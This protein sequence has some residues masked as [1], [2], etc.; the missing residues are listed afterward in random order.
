MRQLFGVFFIFIFGIAYA[1]PTEIVIETFAENIG[2]V[3][4]TDLTGY[5]TFRVYVKFSSPDDFLSAIYGDSDFPTRIYG[6]N[7]FFH[8]AVGGLTNEGYNPLVFPVVP[9][10]EYDSFV[11]IGMDSPANSDDGEQTINSIGDPLANWVSAFEPGAGMPGADLVIDT[12][13]GGSWFPLYPDANAFAG[14]DSMVLIGQFTTNQEFYGELSVASFIEGDMSN[15]NLMTMQFGLPTY[16][17]TDLQACNYNV[18]A[19]L[20]DGSCFYPS[21][22]FLD[23][24]GDCI[25]DSDGDGICDEQ[26]GCTISVACNYDPQAILDD[27]SCEFFCPG[28][29]N[30]S[31]CNFDSTALQEDGTCLFED[32]LGECG[33]TCTQD[34]DNDLVCDDIDP[35]I[36]EYDVCGVCNGPG[37][38]ATCGCS[39]VPEGFCDCNGNQIDALGVC[40]GGCL[41]DADGDGICDDVDDCVGEFDECGVCN[42]AGA[43]YECGCSGIPEGD[44]DCNGSVIDQC[45]NCGGDGQ[46]CVGCMYEFACNFDSNATISDAALCEFGTCPG[47]TDSDAFNYNPTVIED[48]GSCLFLEDFCADESACNYHPDAAEPVGPS[49]Y[50]IEVEVVSENIGPLV[51]PSGTT[52]LTGYTCYR[53][54]ITMENEDDFLS[55]ISGD[56]IN[57]TSVTTTTDFFHALLGNAT[58]NGIN[59]LLFGA[60][61]DTE[62]DSWVTIGLDGIPNASWGEAAV[63]T[64]QS[65]INP[66]T[67]TFDPGG[68]LPGGNI[69]IDDAIGGAW[70]ALNGDANGYAGEDLK[71]LAGQFTTTGDLSLSL[72]TQIFVEGVGSEVYLVNGERPT[73]NWPNPW[74]G[75]SGNNCIYPELYADCDG[76]CL[77]DDDGDGIC[78]D[79]DDC[80]GEIDECGVCNGAN[81]CGCMDALAC[82]Y[83]MEAVFDDAS[84]TYPAADYLDCNGDCLNDEDGDGLCDEEEGCGDP[85]ACNY[86]PTAL[87]EDDDYCLVVDTVLVH[88]SGNLAGMTT[89]RYYVKC[90]NPADFVSAI[91]GD[92]DNPTVITTTTEFYQDELG[93]VT[94]NS[95]VSFLFGTFPDLEYDSFVTIGLS[96]APVSTIGEAAV[97]TVQSGINPWTTTFDPGFGAAGG[98]IVINDAVGG[99]W[100]ALNGD[101]N[102]IAANHPNNEV[103]I[104]QLTTDGEV[105]GNFY[106]QVF[107]NG[108]GSNQ[109]FFNFNIGDACIAPDDDCV[110]AEDV[111][112]VDYRDCDGLC[113]NDADADG[114]CDEEEVAGCTDST[115][116][117]YDSAATDDDGMCEYAAASVFDIIADSE[118]HNFLEELIV[119]AGL[120][121]TLTNDGEWTVFAPTDN[122]VL[123][124]PSNVIDGIL[125]HPMTLNSV[126]TY[127]LASDYVTS[128]MLSD[129]MMIETINGQMATIT[130][131]GGSFFINGA[132]IIIAD[133]FAENGVVHVIDAV[134]LPSID[135]CMDLNACNWNPAADIEDG[136]CEYESCVG[137]LNESACNY[138]STATINAALSCTFPEDLYGADYYDCLGNC[139]NDADGDGICDEA[140][141][142]GCVYEEAC[143]FNPDATEDDGSCEYLVA[144]NRDCA[145]NCLND[146][147][148]DDVCDED[149]IEGC[150]DPVACNYDS[151]A[152]DEDDSCA[153]PEADNRDCAGNCLN[154]AD[155]DDVCD[156]DEIEGCKD[157]VA[158][159][160]DASATDDNSSCFWPSDENCDCLGATVDAIGE[161]GGSCMADLNGNDICDSLEI[162][163]CG[164]GTVWSEVLLQCVGSNDCPTDNNADGY[165]GINDLLN[166]L[167]DFGTFCSE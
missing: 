95:F 163:L 121:G 40:G 9:D 45:G 154:D 122:A 94:P 138:D 159:N 92:A 153:Y 66:W 81:E 113:L 42:G 54:Y 115:A 29:T 60:F 25:N 123:S 124:L 30:S 166:L 161:C 132:E 17:C 151:S 134:L 73:F 118:A 65:G 3:G 155:G 150:T 128:D 62:Y 117:N 85:Y 39:E 26:V 24:D 34:L 84:C 88:T 104:A 33:G 130:V 57:P 58:P 55:S 110:Y 21:A 56:D 1:Q 6:G 107:E 126:L 111:Y 133:V 27:L 167:T 82:N 7:N 50:C 78:D 149:E 146:A 116:L 16:G 22:D 164:P 12:Q 53:A 152:T 106:V 86:D 71:V 109:L 97:T 10:L 158:C 23:C 156:E 72:Y 145:G 37:E 2:I 43:I 11:T 112:G 14:P 28:C 67:T 91:S 70:Y 129:G 68:G 18:D 31:A 127:N 59:S 142:D 5:N 90:A 140:E 101:N 36:G 49:A 87:V 51:G 119:I 93:G 136:S 69:V 32:A 144:D 46:S 147:D 100:F 157:P 105:E 96:E 19:D 131:S 148:G 125:L 15:D 63:S 13:T 20:E 52:D 98:N 80:V 35:C 48:D 137:C 8:S 4:V 89:Y 143:N 64:V 103:L 83:D 160:Y 41:S 75:C 114:V 108:S 47:C 162:A 120:D 102:G 76:N 99:S 165:V 61:P 38:V 74:S 77:H 139:L 79:V 44:C 135:G 141:V